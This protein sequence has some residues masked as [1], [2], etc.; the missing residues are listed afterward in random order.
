MYYAIW[1]P[2]HYA[3]KS[4][5]VGGQY[6]AQIRTVKY[7]LQGREDADPYWRAPTTGDESSLTELAMQIELLSS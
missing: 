7:I 5:C 2:G 4:A 3:E 1:K 6:I